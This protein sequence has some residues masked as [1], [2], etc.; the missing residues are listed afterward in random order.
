VIV[1]G[2]REG[3]I[4]AFGSQE[5]NGTWKLLLAGPTWQ[6]YL[7]AQA[8][9]ISTH[10]AIYDPDGD[11]MLV[12]GGLLWAFILD[13]SP[14][15]S[16][17]SYSLG[18]NPGW[19]YSGEGPNRG[20]HS[21]IHDP[22]RKRMLVFGG[23]TYYGPRLNDVYALSLPSLQWSLVSTTGTLPPE[24][25]AHSAIYDPVRDRMLVF[26]GID[27]PMMIPFGTRMNDAWALRLGNN[28]WTS[29]SPLGSPP[30]PRENHIAVYD[31]LGDRMI[32]FGGRD[33]AGLKNDLWALALAGQESWT[34]L[35]AAGTPPSPREMHSSVYDPSAHRMLVFGGDESDSAVWA[36]D[37]SDPKGIATWSVVDTEGLP[38][39][40][41]Q[42]HT[43]IYDPTGY[44]LAVF[45]GE[46]SYTYGPSVFALDMGEV[47]VGM[48]DAPPVSDFSL[49]V[50]SNPVSREIAVAFSLPTAASTVLELVNVS[51]RRV[52]R[53]DLGTA[54]PGPN[55][56]ILS[57]RRPTAGIYFVRLTHAGR[58]HTTKVSLVP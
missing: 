23:D 36:L 4:G 27:S 1:F 11:R 28:A 21:A 34:S 57:G 2:G 41:R 56:V 37:L 29:L 22:A 19:S 35:A 13:I 32:V 42:D 52:A 5:D 17:W 44:R 14:I 16:L 38:P 30:S 50:L 47:P 31:P 6:P 9:I 51:G 7:D 45:G 58:T 24:R 18:D 15:G 40:G 10:T 26:G 3:S 43:A 12:Y 55:T 53:R 33:A 20:D 48:G 46:C 8:P 49:R 39:A 54:G 25:R